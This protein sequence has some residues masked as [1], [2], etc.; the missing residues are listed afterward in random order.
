MAHRLLTVGKLGGSYPAI[1]QS[2]IRLI[3]ARII[4]TPVSGRRS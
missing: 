2:R 4:A 3:A 1:L